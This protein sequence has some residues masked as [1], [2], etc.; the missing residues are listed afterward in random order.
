MEDGR[1]VRTPDHRDEMYE[2]LEWNGDNELR[3][4]FLF[5]GLR[6]FDRFSFDH[7]AGPIFLKDYPPAP[8]TRDTR[9]LRR[10]FNYGYCG[11][12][13]YITSMSNQNIARA[14]NTCA[15]SYNVHFLGSEAIQIH[16]SILDFMY[17]Y[18][19]P[20]DYLLFAIMDGIPDRHAITK[21]QSALNKGGYNV[22]S[23][24]GSWGSATTK[25]LVDFIRAQDSVFID[26][27]EAYLDLLK[28]NLNNENYDVIYELAL[29]RARSSEPKLKRQDFVLER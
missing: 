10:I 20:R 14:L 3:S 16:P 9:D 11:T 23:T 7:I 22:G 17:K 5:D 29:S 1:F 15:Q 25:G 8:S 21:I 4:D 13:D 19:S 24:D 6:I 27:S 26:V 12:T 2:A 18:S 28:A